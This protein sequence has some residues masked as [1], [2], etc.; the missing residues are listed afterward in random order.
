MSIQQSNQEQEIQNISITDYLRIIYRGRWII[1]F[2]FLAVFT[3]TVYYTFTMHPVYEASTSI[4][5]D[6]DGAMERSLFDFGT[7]IERFL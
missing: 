1:V 6:R 4:I 3:A 2:S 7:F 5:I